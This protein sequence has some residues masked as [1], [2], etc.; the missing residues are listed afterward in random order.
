M[1]VCVS[2]TALECAE[3]V[4]AA[5]GVLDTTGLESCGTGPRAT[6]RFTQSDAR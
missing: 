1:C 2:L 6:V 3:S 4:L 5:L